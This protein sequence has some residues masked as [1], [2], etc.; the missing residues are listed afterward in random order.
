MIWNK[1]IGIWI[2]I[3]INYEGKQEYKWEQQQEK[4]EIE[5]VMWS[6]CRIS[7]NGKNQKCE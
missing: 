6:K 4:I 2:K 3:D 1:K 5:I 7:R